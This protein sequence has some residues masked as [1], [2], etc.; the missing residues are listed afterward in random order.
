MTNSSA[1]RPPPGS[2]RTAWP[3]AGR[4]PRRA[5]AARIIRT[6]S[7][8]TRPV[9]LSKPGLITGMGTP[10]D[11]LPAAVAA[12]AFLILAHA[13]RPAYPQLGF[14]PQAAGGVVSAVGF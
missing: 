14:Y 2:V 8:T 5:A 13:G 6:I 9:G 7:A 10:L 3:W 4:Y 1:A 12:L 11:R